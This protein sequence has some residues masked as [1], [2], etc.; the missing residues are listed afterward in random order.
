MM[1]ELMESKISKQSKKSHRT[2]EVI[3]NSPDAYMDYPHIN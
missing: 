1:S 3:Y 2:I